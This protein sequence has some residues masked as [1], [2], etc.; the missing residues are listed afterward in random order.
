[1]KKTLNIIG[2]CLGIF[3]ICYGITGS[4]SFFEGLGFILFGLPLISW[5]RNQLMKY[6]QSKKKRVLTYIGIIITSLIF[7]GIGAKP[8]S[9]YS[10]NNLDNNVLVDK[11][12]KELTV[13]EILNNPKKYEGKDIAVQGSL[14]T[15]GN[16][17]VNGDTSNIRP[18]LYGENKE[19]L[20]L[21]GEWPSQVNVK[22]VIVYGK[23]SIDKNEICLTVEK[24]NYDNAI[25]I[26]STQNSIDL[27]STL[28]SL[29]EASEGY[30]N[31]NW[32]QFIMNPTS[33]AGTYVYIPGEVVDIDIA[34]GQTTGLISTDEN[35]NELVSFIIKGEVYD[36]SIGSY[37]APTGYISESTGSAYNNVTGET[38]NTP[39]IVVENPSLW[40]TEYEVDLSDKEIQDFLYGT[41]KAIDSND[42]DK[43]L[44]ESF[45]FNSKTI[46]GYSYQF[47]DMS[48]LNPVLKVGTR[49][50]GS[51][52]SARIG[53]NIVSNEIGTAPTPESQ[54]ITTFSVDLYG[55]D[56]L[57]NSDGHT[58]HYHKK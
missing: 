7:V 51:A 36:F 29:K 53:M 8:I 11:N 52:T 28:S 24:Y 55:N 56:V 12:N 40:K 5:F 57:I 1:M 54:K 48:Q 25:T 30:V 34:N 4:Y 20:V 43:N 33:L 22:N 35:S 49:D 17:F 42:V 47:K 50:Y 31:L 32:N 3:C 21:L 46:G 16:V 10:D 18:A 39:L 41:Y 26:Q 45:I 27:H 6:V 37:I 13:D 2:I 19:Y 14:L 58:H 23:I 9:D 38:V 15:G 44:G